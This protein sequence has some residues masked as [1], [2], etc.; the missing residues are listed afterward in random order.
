[1]LLLQTEKRR[2]KP[3]KSLKKPP[4]IP[5]FFYNTTMS[6]NHPSNILFIYVAKFMNNL[7]YK[8]VIPNL[9]CVKNHVSRFVSTAIE[10]YP[11]DSTWVLCRENP[12]NVRVYIS[13]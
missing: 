2:H 6:I 4:K 10:M 12:H 11:S 13:K 8:E 5:P 3:K 7:R 9:Q 1:M